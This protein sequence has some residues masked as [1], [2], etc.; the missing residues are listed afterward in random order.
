[1]FIYWNELKLLFKHICTIVL[2]AW[3]ILCALSLM[4]IIIFTGLFIWKQENGILD[5]GWACFRKWY[6]QFR[7]LFSSLPSI[8]LSSR[9]GILWSTYC[10]SYLFSPARDGQRQNSSSSWKCARDSLCSFAFHLVL[11]SLFL[12][13]DLKIYVRMLCNSYIWL[14]NYLLVHTKCHGAVSCFVSFLFV[15]WLRN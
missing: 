13:E 5:V 7:N 12:L 3:G 2:V 1:M 10:K 14:C 9:D 11:L 8:W 15:V 4:V 6:C